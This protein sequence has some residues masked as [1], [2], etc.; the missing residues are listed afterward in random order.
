VAPPNPF[1]S[2][3]MTPLK[4]INAGWIAV[5]PYGF[6]PPNQPS[7]YFTDQSWKWWGETTEG[8]TTTI[9]LAH[10]AGLKVMMK[11]QIYIPGKWTG[12]LNFST[13]AQWEKWEM[14]YTNYILHFAKIAASN[15]VELFCIGTEFNLAIQSRQPF[16]LQLIQK[17]KAIYSGK[18]VYSANWDDWEKVP[19]WEHLDY[20]GL[21]GY[22]PLIQT[23]TPDKNALVQAWAPIRE[24]LQHFSTS[25]Q[26]PVLF[27]EY[28]YLSVDS[29]GWRNWELEHGVQQRT[30][31]EQAQAN[32]LD[33]LHQVFQPE[34]WWAG[35]FLWKWFPNG[36]GH[37]GYPER[38]YTPQQKLGEKILKKWFS[39]TK[40]TAT[41][42]AN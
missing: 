39:T 33:A 41:Q 35:G 16:W 2:N 3:P 28:G 13:E 14:E 7:V 30:I 22:F 17:I 25:L 32:C 9:Q 29:C 15:N 31:N 26:K 1:P 37:E 34:H 4:E 5:V 10:A 23:A 6:T 42:S 21:G 8:A 24:R 38:D 40:T 18:L 19:F 12:S 36:E 20:I 27:T 11:P